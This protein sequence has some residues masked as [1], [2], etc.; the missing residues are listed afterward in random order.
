MIENKLLSTKLREIILVVGKNAIADLSFEIFCDSTSP[1]AS[2][3]AIRQAFAR[4]IIAFYKKHYD[5]TKAM[6]LM[7]R[8]MSHDKSSL[9]T[10][11][12]RTEPKK[13]GG[14]GA[15]ARYQKSYR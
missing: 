15:R 10:D 12:R 3:Y 2:V 14:P 6:E 8:L 7:R 1:T 5:E 9:V 11:S 4:S 13:Y